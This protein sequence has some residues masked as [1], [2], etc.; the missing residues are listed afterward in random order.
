V[1]ILLKQAK[2]LVKFDP[3][4]KEHIEAFRSVYFNGKQHPTLRFELEEGYASVVSMASDKLLRR[5]L[6]HED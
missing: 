6:K 5:F 2:P 1:S 3:K 4:N